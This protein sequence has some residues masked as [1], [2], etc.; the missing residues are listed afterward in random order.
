MFRVSDLPKRH[1]VS[2]KCLI[3]VSTGSCDNTSSNHWTSFSE[4]TTYDLA[5]FSWD[6]VLGG[7][8]SEAW[9][10]TQEGWSLCMF[11]STMVLQRSTLTDVIKRSFPYISEWETDWRWLTRTDK[12]KVSSN[13][14]ETTLLCVLWR[15]WVVRSQFRQFR[16]GENTPMCGFR[17]SC[18]TSWPLTSHLLLFKGV[19]DDVGSVDIIEG[20]RRGCSMMFELFQ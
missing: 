6:E 3:N 20:H 9:P 17:G 11:D 4:T 1:P 15:T 12:T 13:L 7:K 19:R 18:N 5:L 16:D 8:D 14:E 10:E 2:R